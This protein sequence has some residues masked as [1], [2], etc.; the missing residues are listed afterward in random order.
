MTYAHA[1]AIVLDLAEQ[2]LADPAE[3][4]KAY[5]RQLEALRI[6]RKN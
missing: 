5:A 1:L 4:P 2:N 6:V 3:L